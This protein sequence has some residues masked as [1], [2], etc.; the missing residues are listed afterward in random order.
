MLPV[1]Y[2]VVPGETMLLPYMAS[3]F[4]STMYSS[5][6]ISD[7][8]WSSST[9]VLGSFASKR[10]SCPEYGTGTLNARGGLP[11]HPLVPV[12]LVDNLRYDL[13][14]VYAGPWQL[15]LEET[16]LSGVRNRNPECSGVFEHE[17]KCLDGVVSPCMVKVGVGIECL[18]GVV[19]FYIVQLGHSHDRA[20]DQP[21]VNA[22][23]CTIGRSYLEGRVNQK[24]PPEIRVPHPKLY[25]LSAG[26][27][28]VCIVF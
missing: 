24:V 13:V 20:R 5:S 16:Q 23:P 8:I 22:K 11:S 10:P 15:C 17:P 14:V 2:Y 4:P 19:P 7:T 1:L 3:A 27:D 21:L 18:G 9:P 25:G 28:E 26:Y 6:I 12:L